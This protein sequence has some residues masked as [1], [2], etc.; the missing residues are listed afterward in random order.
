MALPLYGYSPQVPGQLQPWSHMRGTC[1][2]I[3]LQLPI[4]DR[5][6]N[7][8]AQDQIVRSLHTTRQFDCREA[9]SVGIAGLERVTGLVSFLGAMWVNAD[10]GIDTA[11]VR[12]RYSATS[13]YRHRA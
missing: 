5:P 12:N 4:L 8:Q 1:G 9:K 7:V 13:R 11:P 3:R 2:V 10:G 6:W